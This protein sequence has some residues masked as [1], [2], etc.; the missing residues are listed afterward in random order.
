MPKTTLGW[1]A[2][3]QANRAIEDGLPFHLLNRM[4]PE[5]VHDASLRFW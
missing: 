1:I 5:Q 2:Y 4:Q 3:R